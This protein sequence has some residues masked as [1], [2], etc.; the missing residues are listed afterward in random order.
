MRELFN[1]AEF[2]SEEEGHV[3]EAEVQQY[4]LQRLAGGPRRIGYAEFADML[5]ETDWFP[6]DLQRA[7]GHLIKEGR[8]RNLD[9]VGKRRTKFVHLDKDG[10]RLELVG[11]S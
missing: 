3:S 5:E 11:E 2:V 6:A 9:A 7:L 8:V 4:W 10:E 1:D